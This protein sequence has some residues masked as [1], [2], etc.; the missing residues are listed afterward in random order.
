MRSIASL[1]YVVAMGVVVACGG[2]EVTRAR[3]QVNQDAGPS[4]GGG[5][6]PG[7][8]ASPGVGTGGAPSTATGGAPAGQGDGG[9]NPQGGA[10]TGGVAG[11]ANCLA[12]PVCDA[13]DEQ[14]LDACP[15]GRH[16]YDRTM[17]GST[18][19]CAHS[20][21]ADAGACS[22]NETNRRYV[23][24]SPE[25]CAA[26]RFRCEANTTAFSNEC[27]CG[28]EQDPSCPAWVDCMPTF[29]PPYPPMDPL[30]GDHATCPFTLRAL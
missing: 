30:C 28:C 5:G 18:I 17:C 10:N 4:T 14:V 2:T 23:G 6:G 1:T 19:V 15:S 21:G 26:I 25:E 24:K 27:G 20:V 29:T 13:G 7:T 16:C 9:R 3:S 11:Y 12:L 22:L 8:G